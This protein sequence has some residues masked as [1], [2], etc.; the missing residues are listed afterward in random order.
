MSSPDI[1]T[2]LNRV[3]VI[4][5]R[6][7]PQYLVYARPYIPPGRE[8]VMETVEQIV[9]GQNALAERVAQHIFDAEG[10]PDHGDFP[11]DFTDMHDL[12][13]DY[14]LQEAIDCLKQDVADLQTCADALRSAPAAQSL[15][16][17][18]VGLTKGHVELL[19]K[20]VPSSAG[21][22]TAGG[23]SAIANDAPVAKEN[24]DVPHRPE[25]AKQ[26]AGGGNS[27]G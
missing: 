3:L 8:G 9:A 16:G 12:G 23:T 27:M 14:L 15:A 21:S 10:L 24:G 1:I 25:D 26:L 7:L 11:I 6:S 5:E 13:I 2:T 22:T 19:Q 17:E 18:A 20:L 4:L